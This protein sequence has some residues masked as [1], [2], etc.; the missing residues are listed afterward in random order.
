MII[1]HMPHSKPPA[2]LTLYVGQCTNAK[3]QLTNGPHQFHLFVR[4]SVRTHLG[5][6]CSIMDRNYCSQLDQKEFTSSD[7]G[8]SQSQVHKI[9]GFV[10][11]CVCMSPDSVAMFFWTGNRLPLD[12]NVK[13]TGIRVG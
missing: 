11:V 12:S 7:M 5:M 8:K 9:V 2:I 3:F 4:N 1:S 13:A 10:P 6:H